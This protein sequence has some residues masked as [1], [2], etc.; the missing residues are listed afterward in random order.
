MIDSKMPV[1]P[2]VRQAYGYDG[3][4]VSAET[5]LLCLDESLT[6]QSEKDE[7]DINTI[8][9]RFGLTGELPEG[10]R[11]PTYGDFTQVFDFQSAQN[12]LVAARESFMEMP[13]DVRY[14]FKNDPQEFV[15]FCSNPDNLDEMRKLGLAVPAKVTP[16]APDVD[17]D[18]K[19]VIIAPPADVPPK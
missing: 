14:R 9:K 5:G 15:D 17:K 3:D 10:V 4:A 11:P 8:V 18:G 13:A 7:S 16:P 2:V 1:F 12:A 19:P 6:L